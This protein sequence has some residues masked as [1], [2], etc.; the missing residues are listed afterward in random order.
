MGAQLGQNGLD[1]TDGL[2]QAGRHGFAGPLGRVA[3]EVS[4]SAPEPGG[5]PQFSE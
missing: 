2:A 4:G 3:P 5:S 1:P